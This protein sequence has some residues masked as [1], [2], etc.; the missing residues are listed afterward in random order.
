LQIAVVTIKDKR[1]ILN[2]AAITR[3]DPYSEALSLRNA[4]DQ[5]L[6]QS[7]V[8]PSWGWGWSR[9]Q[10]MM[11]PMDVCQ[12]DNGY[13]VNVALPGVNPQDIDV[14]V[15]QNTIDIKGTFNYQHQHEQNQP[16]QQSQQTVQMQGQGQQ[17]GET[18]N[19][20]MREIGSGT[21]ERTITLP[22]PIDADKIESSY[23]DGILTL[24]IPLSESSRPRKINVNKGQRQGQP[25]TVESR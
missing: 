12:T 20:L 3:Y 15:H 13:E 21:F 18:H 4:M 6:A 23:H 14:T 2:M 9:T 16:R 22:Q 7:F 19:W 10:T 8:N 17:R 5:L 11:A 1:R 25:V 24:N